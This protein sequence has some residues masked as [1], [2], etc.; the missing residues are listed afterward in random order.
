[1]SVCLLVI[2]SRW[3]VRGGHEARIL[4]CAALDMNAVIKFTEPLFPLTEQSIFKK[5]SLK[6]A[7]LLGSLVTEYHA[8]C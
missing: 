5:N 4:F 1:V 7:S 3:T 6:S 2:N 8:G